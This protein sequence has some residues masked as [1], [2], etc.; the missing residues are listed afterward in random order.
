MRAI[1]LVSDKIPQ[2]ISLFNDTAAIEKRDK[3]ET[4]MESI[5][6]RYGKTAITYACL[7]GDL[8]MPKT[9]DVELIMPTGM[10]K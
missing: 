2:Q 3:V 7:M 8:K 1:N 10:V 5:R 6:E 4:A 9:K